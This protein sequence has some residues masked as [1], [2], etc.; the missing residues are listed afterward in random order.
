MYLTEDT[1]RFPCLLEILWILGDPFRRYNISYTHPPV[2][3]HCGR[4]D[5]TNFFA[6]TTCWTPGQ[7][8]C[9]QSAIQ[10]AIQSVIQS[11]LRSGAY[12]PA[13]SWAFLSPYEIYEFKFLNKIKFKKEFNLINF[14]SCRKVI[15]FGEEHTVLECAPYRLHSALNPA[16]EWSWLFWFLLAKK[17]LE[18]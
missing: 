8:I 7:P 3:P 10:S 9:R 15:N 11:A 5:C 17:I 2:R 1:T 4:A 6:I 14:G 16:N 18:F 12:C 13:V